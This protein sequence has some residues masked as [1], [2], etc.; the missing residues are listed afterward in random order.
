[1]QSW[2]IILGR[3]ED[4]VAALD[5]RPDVLLPGGGKHLLEVVD[6]N[7]RVSRHVDRAQ[8]S[9]G[10]AYRLPPRKK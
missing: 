8:E 2:H 10:R 1:M 7:D 9:N 3:V 4:D 6:A 5:K